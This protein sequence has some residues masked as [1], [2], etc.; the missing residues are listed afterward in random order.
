M[1]VVCDYS[2]ANPSAPNYEGRIKLKWSTFYFHQRNVLIELFYFP[3]WS[4]CS[5][6]VACSL[7]FPHLTNPIYPLN[8]SLKCE[9]ISQG[10]F[11]PIGVGITQRSSPETDIPSL[12]KFSS[13]VALVLTAREDWAEIEHPASQDRPC[14]A[15]LTRQL[16]V[17]RAQPR[18]LSLLL[19]EHIQHE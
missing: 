2:H 13:V 8:S 14:C 4:A 17:L 15:A 7:A 16:P 3:W 19:K 10:N 6:G 18:K 1:L 9:E 11:S 5:S 12:I